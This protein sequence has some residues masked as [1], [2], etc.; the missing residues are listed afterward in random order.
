MGQELKKGMRID[1][2]EILPD[3][4]TA[5]TPVGSQRLVYPDEVELQHSIGERLYIDRALYVYGHYNKNGIQDTYDV[6]LF[7]E[8]V[9]PIGCFVVKEVYS[10][11][12]SET[13]I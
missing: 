6:F 13:I 11:R 1:L 5:F 12:D 2:V 8:E 3:G 10:N 9:K 4:L 7:K